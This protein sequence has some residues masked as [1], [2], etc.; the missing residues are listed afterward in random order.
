MY[1]RKTL[2]LTNLNLRPRIFFSIVGCLCTV[3]RKTELQT[4]KELSSTLHR[5]TR[6]LNHPA[7]PTPNHAAVTSQVP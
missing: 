3:L 4:Y 2:K 1:Q 5:A 7:I 6:T